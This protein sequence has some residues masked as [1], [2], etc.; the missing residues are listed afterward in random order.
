MDAL[1]RFFRSTLFPDLPERVVEAVVRVHDEP[2]EPTAAELTQRGDM[3]AAEGDIDGA[4]AQYRRAVRQ[5][6]G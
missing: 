6:G 2:E 3:L 1:R 4:M 5:G